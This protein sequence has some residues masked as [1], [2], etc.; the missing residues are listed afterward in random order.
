[1][2]FDY[3]KDF[4]L[5]IN[6]AHP[7]IV[8]LNTLRKDDPKLAEQVSKA[9]LDQV[10]LSNQIPLDI[11]QSATQW[12]STLEAY[13]DQCL[14]GQDQAQSSSSSESEA[15]FEPVRED[16]NANESIL[17]QHNEMR[18]KSE[19]DGKKVYKEYKVTG[20]EKIKSD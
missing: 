9:F 5:E 16:K 18:Q 3:P 15:E 14:D 20:K 2:Q 1:M 4:T 10:L 7:I 13:M 11:E 12:S 8:N 19:G 6:A 17:N